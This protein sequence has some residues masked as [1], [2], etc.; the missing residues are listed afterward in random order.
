[1]SESCSYTA[2]VLQRQ[3]GHPRSDNSDNSVREEGE[4][5]DS[6]IFPGH[7]EIG[8]LFQERLTAAF[9]GLLVG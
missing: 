7:L 1:M 2:R 8:S 3:E 6:P 5:K 9:S 4:I